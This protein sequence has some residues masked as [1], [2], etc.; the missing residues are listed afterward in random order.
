[1]YFP[2]LVLKNRRLLA[3]NDLKG[4]DIY[5]KMVRLCEERMKF[6]KEGVGERKPFFGGHLGKGMGRAK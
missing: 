4:R 3:E 1:M 2:G 6:L 5:M